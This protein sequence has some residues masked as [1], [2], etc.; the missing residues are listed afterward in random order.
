MFQV[1]ASREFRF[2]RSHERVASPS[3]TTTVLFRSRL[4]TIM[5]ESDSSLSLQGKPA[6]ARGYA[7]HSGMVRLG[8]GIIA[9]ES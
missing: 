9:A 2:L 4:H 6:P 7:L 8:N 3:P 5:S 1:A